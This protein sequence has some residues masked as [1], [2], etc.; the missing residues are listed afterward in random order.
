MEEK[1]FDYMNVIPL[2][3]IMLVLLTIV[4]TTATFV[5]I[6]ALPV[7]LPSAQEG[8]RVT[9]HKDIVIT[10]DSQGNYY[11]GRKK[12]SFEDIIGEI[13]KLD[14]DIRININADK[15]VDIEYFV[16]LFSMLRS[17]GFT[18]IHLLVESSK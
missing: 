1:E 10:I 5:N 11:M 3:D 14:R 17:E 6:E 16:K 4:L 9:Q 15:T 13:R 18:N 2:V 7:S 8:E 12:L